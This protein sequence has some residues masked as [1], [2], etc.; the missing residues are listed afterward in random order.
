MPAE[1]T[2]L[3][4]LVEVVVLVDVEVAHAFPYSGLYDPGLAAAALAL[5][6]A[7]LALVTI[8]IGKAG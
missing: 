3:E 8:R 7:A 1:P 5:G 6:V 4:L 2:G